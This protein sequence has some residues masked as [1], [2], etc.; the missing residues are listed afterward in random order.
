MK[1]NIIR[2]GALKISGTL[3]AGRLVMA[4]LLFLAAGLFQSVY[5]QADKP[6]INPVSPPYI[7]RTSNFMAI[8]F[9]VKADEVQK[10]L[11]ANVK[12]KSDDKGLATGGM[13]IYTTDQIYGMPKYT[14]AFIYVEVSTPDSNNSTSGNWP[15]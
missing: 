14:I 1:Q 4:V 15:I 12:V 9:R 2:K 5:G 8:A 11:P 3:P 13:E 7:A 6:A 10:L